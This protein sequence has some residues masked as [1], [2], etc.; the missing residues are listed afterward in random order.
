MKSESKNHLGIRL[1]NIYGV[2]FAVSDTLGDPG[3][4]G[5]S[6]AQGRGRQKARSPG[7]GLGEELP[8]RKGGACFS[9]SPHGPQLAPVPRWPLPAQLK[10]PAQFPPWRHL[11]GYKRLLQMAPEYTS[12]ASPATLSLS[13]GLD[14]G[15]C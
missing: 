9:G 1:L 7:P 3:D 13:Q 12:L 15:S 14:S 10:S 8:A 2:V 6:K 5:V 11:G 4:T